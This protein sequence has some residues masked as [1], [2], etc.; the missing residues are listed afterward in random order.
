MAGFGCLLYHYNQWWQGK[1]SILSSVTNYEYFPSKGGLLFYDSSGRFVTARQVVSVTSSCLTLAESGTTITKCY[2]PQSSYATSISMSEPSVNIFLDNTKQLSLVAT[3]AE[4]NMCT[5]RW[6]SSN[7]YVATVSNTGLVTAKGIGSA[8]ITAH[9]GAKTATCTVTV[10]KPVEGLELTLNTCVLPCNSSFV[11]GTT[12]TPLDATNKTLTWKSGNASIASVVDGKVTTGSKVGKVNITANTTDGTDLSAMCAVKVI[13]VSPTDLT[14]SK[15]KANLTPGGA[16]Q[17]SAT[18]APS[19]A[20]DITVIWS[21]SNKD[22]AT[23]DQTGKVTVKTHPKGDYA[24]IYANIA[25]TSITKTCTLTVDDSSMYVDL[26]LPSGIL[27]ATM[28]VGAESPEEYGNYY[29]WGET[30]AYGEVDTSNSH[31]YSYKLNYKKTDYNCSTYKWCS[32]DDDQWTLTKY[33]AVDGKT[34]LELAD[35]AAY[36]NWGTKWRMPTITELEELRKNCTWTWTTMNGIEGYRVISKKDS[37][38][39]IFLPTAGYRADKKLC[40]DGTYGYYSSS[41]IDPDNL[42]KERVLYF[43]SLYIGQTT[44]DREHGMNVRAVRR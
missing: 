20:S 5:A 25:G 24:I 11:I 6:S 2:Y 43:F 16:L 9:S 35:D 23:V 38:K 7:T 1:V 27:W 42:N 13:N 32:G 18:I 40:G 33:C 10:T 26:G 15:T 30:K 3:P 21:S 34:T 22:V 37:S 29:A 14:L 31:N 39:S 17:L 8:T 41:S 44:R 36:V 19:S 28:N 12:I 4:A